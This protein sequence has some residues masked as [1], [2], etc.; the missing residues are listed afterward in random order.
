MRGHG[1]VQVEGSVT[2]VSV[3]SPGP[4]NP[5]FPRPA[6]PA[7]AVISMWRVHRCSAEGGAQ[8]QGDVDARGLVAGDDAAQNDGAV[9]IAR[10]GERLAAFDDASV[11]TQRLHQM[12]LPGS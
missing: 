7:A 4:A 6:V 3:C 8:A 10:V 11:V 5:K 12:R 2:I 1:Q 9:W